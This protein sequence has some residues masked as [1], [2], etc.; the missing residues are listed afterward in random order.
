MGLWSVTRPFVAFDAC[1]V[2]VALIV[3]RPGRAHVEGFARVPLEPGALVPSPAGANLVRPDE[4]TEALARALRTLERT[5]D[6]ATLVLPDGVARL[7]PLDVPSGAE[8][9]DYARFRLASSLPWPASEGTFEV[10]RLGRRAVGA[11]IRRATVARYEQL[12]SAAGLSV[13]QVH[14]APLLAVQGLLARGRGRRDALHVVLGDMALCLVLVREGEMLAFRS[15]RRDPGDA[16]A[17]W[18]RSEAERATRAVPET[19][20]GFD[21]VVSG[22]GAEELR[23]ALGASVL[24]ADFTPEGSAE[25]PDAAEAGWIVGALA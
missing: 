14:L 1:S 16:E 23:G 8:P 9:R 20:G 25:W 12:A 19:N 22:S 18:L 4:V 24:S 13:D 10:L 2:S 5:P 17:R 6:R 15:R 7:A 21:I 11:A 3:R